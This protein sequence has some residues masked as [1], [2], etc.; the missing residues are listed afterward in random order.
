MSAEWAELLIFFDGS[1]E[2]ARYLRPVFA[3]EVRHMS[4][5]AP[6]SDG[7]DS[8]VAAWLEPLLRR[9]KLS[10]QAG[11]RPSIEAHLPADAKKHLVAQIELIRVELELRLQAGEAARVEEYLE[12]FPEVA[13]DRSAVFKLLLAEW[14][15]R[16]AREPE[17]TIEEYRR[18]FPDFEAELAEA[19]ATLP[20]L[21]DR[22]SVSATHNEPSG[23]AKAT[24]D[25]MMPHIPGYE[26]EKILAHGGMGIVY[27]AKQTALKR[28]V[29]LKMILGGRFNQ[30][31]DRRRFFAEAHALARLSHPNIVQIH[32]IGEYQSQPFLALEYVEGG[33]LAERIARAPL[34]AADAARMTAILARALHTAHLADIV[35]RDIKPAN[36]LMTSD[37]VPKVGDFG[38]AKRLDADGDRTLSGAILGTPQYMAP[39][40]AVGKSNAIG[41]YTDVYALGV[42]L[43]EMLTGHVPFRGMSKIDVLQQVTKDEPP[44]V[45]RFNAKAPRDLET[46]CLKCLQ[47]EPARRYGSALELAEDL[48]RFL[49]GEP[50]LARRSS[51]W[52]RGVKWARRRPAM[53]TLFSVLLLS[54]AAA[55]EIWIYKTLQLQYALDDRTRELR[56]EQ[57]ARVEDERQRR[58][59][60]SRQLYVADMRDAVQ[61]WRGG[62]FERCRDVL[63]R[64]L[65]AEGEVDHRGFEWKWLMHESQ[66]QR[67][68]LEM[69]PRHALCLVCSPDGKLLASANNDGSIALWDATEHRLLAYFGEHKGRI[70]ALA[71]SPDGRTLTSAGNDGV[72]KIWDVAQRREASSLFT[73]EGPCDLTPDGRLAAV[74]ASEV[75]LA[76]N[77]KRIRVWDI[78]AKREIFSV[79]ETKNS[80]RTVRIAADG[81]TMAVQTKD[82]PVTIYDA[83]S[84][85][86]RLSCGDDKS[87][88]FC[89]ARRLPLFA[90][91]TFQGDVVL[92]DTLT[93]RQWTIIPRTS[94]VIRF[95]AFRSDDRFLVLGGEDGTLT[96]W[97]VGE[98][99]IAGVFRGHQGEI[100]GASFAPNGGML[101]SA[102]ND[103]T[104][105]FWDTNSPRYP[106]RFKSSFRP[107][108]PMA[109]T[110][111]G[112]LLAAAAVDSS[113]HLIDCA[114]AR[115][116]R[117][118]RGWYG[119]CFAVAFSPDDGE[120]ASAGEDGRIYLWDKA[121]GKRKAVL[122][123]RDG[124]VLAL[125][126]SPDGRW[127]ASVGE[128]GHTR[129]RRRSNGELAATL[130][131]QFGSSTPPAFSS[132]S[133][134]LATVGENRTVLLWD[135]PS[136]QRR[137]EL[138]HH[139]A[140]LFVSFL[141]DGKTLLAHT[142]RHPH[143][144][145]SA[146]GKEKP[147]VPSADLPGRYFAL[148]RGCDILARND[149][150]DIYFSKASPYRINV[151]I[152]H[153]CER[154]EGILALSPD[155]KTLAVARRDAVIQLWDT[156]TW[157]IR[158]VA[159]QPSAAIFSLAFSPDGGV[160]VGG[161]RDLEDANALEWKFL[162]VAMSQTARREVLESI[163]SWRLDENSNEMGGASISS[164][165]SHPIVAFS[166]D[167]QTLASGADD[168]SVSLWD[169]KTGKRRARLLVS[170]HSRRY[171]PL[172]VDHAL[173]LGVPIHAD[174]RSDGMRALAFSPDGRLLA[175]ACEDGLV[176]LW[177]A[178]TGNEW[179]ALPGECAD[180][181]CI[182]FSPDSSTLAV[183]NGSQIELWDVADR[184]GKPKQRKTIQ[185]HLATIRCLAFSRDGRWLASGADDWDIHLWRADTGEMVK[186]FH[187][188]AAR[189]TS[190]AFSADGNTLASAS[191][192]GTVRLWRREAGRELATMTHGTARIHAVAFS[193]A[194]D[195]LAAGGEQTNGRGEVWI[196]KTGP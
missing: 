28:T 7:F 25:A 151:R 47:K 11:E 23:S 27:K 183:N 86:E 114:D 110:S 134:M 71:F 111:D 160:L 82:G 98:R 186:S 145:D 175:A 19:S 108:G 129:V 146:L 31:E 93:G 2:N 115:T 8:T 29:A 75:R 55:V 52:E 121:T 54:F 119:T 147:G 20:L 179:A 5:P 123:G 85:E 168:G 69:S 67:A 90:L 89:F 107:A 73:C 37:G 140:V 44:S 53:A 180:I 187:G 74:G 43:F 15:T 161:T 95:L 194:G 124:P 78:A 34:S 144:W 131:G 9:F 143:L 162:E 60:V 191:W 106:G 149:G 148:A 181:S 68:K 139:S 21:T 127:L 32:E 13:R 38:L 63:R 178:S 152:Q 154:N 56:N 132:R 101:L 133:D 165:V 105:R 51:L 137:A 81:K 33:T 112:R 188:H 109:F 87:P 4:T 141:R 116:I 176:Q 14:R 169:R 96:L 49:A 166:A 153:A 99:R 50:I 65:P 61:F 59:D 163:R 104:I 97:D 3:Q 10:W 185:K 36:I 170:R 100:S 79:G 26:I 158:D 172:V 173:K 159:D 88:C 117:I 177:D 155:G 125:A 128:D 58:R 126:Y 130:E 156:S 150:L 66:R 164:L 113:I 35:H 103:R 42:V 46:I 1:R 16:A 193:P 41:P 70:T 18:R 45:R 184:E 84:G 174:F 64:Q 6:S 136:F 12:R 94:T 17:L 83:A 77:Y 118:L 190:L 171:L 48:E 142:E 122:A 195:V 92:W 138:K 22:G 91:A 182:V 157:E 196:W 57:E 167:G 76:G 189:V 135:L 80:A 40:Q 39:E 192:D 62:D 102:G 24:P 72:I 120:L 30:Q